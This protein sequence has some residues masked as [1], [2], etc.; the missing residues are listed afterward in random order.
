MR[1][2]GVRRRAVVRTIGFRRRAV[3]A[4]FV[5]DGDVVVLAVFCGGRDYEPILRNQAAPCATHEVICFTT[6]LLFQPGRRSVACAAARNRSGLRPAEGAWQRRHRTY[7]GRSDKS[8]ITSISEKI[9]A[10]VARAEGFLHGW[11]SS[12]HPGAARA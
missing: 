9:L 12:T 10:N 3:V 2:I 8:E 7:L 4:S 1:T 11:V 5:R 6:A